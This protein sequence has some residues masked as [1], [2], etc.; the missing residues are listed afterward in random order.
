LL[1]NIK[2]KYHSESSYIGMLE[3]FKKRK[4]RRDLSFPPLCVETFAAVFISQSGTY[5]TSLSLQTK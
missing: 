1:Y 2:G 5:E 3:G 4:E